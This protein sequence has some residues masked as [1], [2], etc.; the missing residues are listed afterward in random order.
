MNERLLNAGRRVFG[1][2][3]T[4]RQRI[5]P[6]SSRVLG[7]TVTNARAAKE[8]INYE[9][10]AD[11]LLNL[12]RTARAQRIV[13]VAVAVVLLLILWSAFASIDEVTRGEGKVIPSRQL[14]V[15][16][17]LDGGVVSEILVLEGQEVDA[18]QML[19]RIDET[20]ATSGVRESAAQAFA[21]RVKQARLKALGEGVAFLPPAARAGDVEEQRIIDEERNLYQSRVSELNSNISISRQQLLQ[22]EQE[23]TEARAR[24]ARETSGR[25]TRP[26]AFYRCRRG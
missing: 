12:E 7:P 19:L 13:R 3:E 24:R 2:L 18:G 9:L 4:L 1:T 17:S 5:E 21:L 6:L 23:L 15:V 16:Q 14:Q 25:S 20:R 26:S 22:R 8:A 10:E 11:E